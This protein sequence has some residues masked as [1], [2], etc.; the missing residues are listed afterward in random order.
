MAF[1]ICILLMVAAVA[2]LI[3][4]AVRERLRQQRVMQRLEGEKT[5]PG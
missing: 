3:N 4:I 1:V 2:L 5:G